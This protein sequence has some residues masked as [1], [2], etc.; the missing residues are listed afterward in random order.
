[1]GSL[2]LVGGKTKLQQ[3]AHFQQALSN[4]VSSFCKNQPEDMKYLI[5]RL[6]EVVIDEPEE[7]TDDML[8]SLSAAIFVSNYSRKMDRREKSTT[9]YTSNKSIICGVVL[10]QCDMSTQ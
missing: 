8:K 9:S 2:S 6:E 5:E 3:F 4:G 10:G 1:M 7:P